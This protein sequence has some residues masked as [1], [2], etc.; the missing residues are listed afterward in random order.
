MDLTAEEVYNID[1]DLRVSKYTSNR[2][3]NRQSIT[4]MV[5]VVK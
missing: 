2:R 4:P 3:D 5:L 1:S